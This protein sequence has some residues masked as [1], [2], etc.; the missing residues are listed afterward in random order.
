MCRICIFIGIIIIGCSS[1]IKAVP[2][3]EAVSADGQCRAVLTVVP[4]QPFL[5]D[6]I[7]LTLDVTCPDDVDVEFPLFGETLG[8]LDIVD[9]KQTDRKLVLKAIPRNAGT[10]P[11]WAMTIKCGQQK[12]DIPDTEIVIATNIDNENVSL[13]DIG[14]TTDPIP[15]KIPYV[16]VIVAALVLATVFFLWLS[17]KRKKADVSEAKHALSAQEL[18]LR[19]LVA[20]LESRKHES[21]IKGFFVELSDIVRWYVE[22][23]SGIRAPELTT[24]EFLHQIATPVRRSWGSF[25]QPTVLFTHSLEKLIP[26]LESA[27]FV[28][29]AKHVPTKDE[30]MLAF[31]RAEDFVRSG[32]QT[33][34]H[35][36]T[37]PNF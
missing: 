10:T 14:L 5:A 6:T 1:F 35:A 31:R 12:I 17:Y 19:R 9:V 15:E 18:A 4:I 36:P 33:S 24:E 32:E 25:E 21:D 26:F 34:E 37:A 20:L 11:I 7:T 3:A 27:D 29:F 13:D 30:I 23:L 22:R 28:K 16:Y 8:E 2:R